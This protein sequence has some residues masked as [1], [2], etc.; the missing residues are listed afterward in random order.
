ML[1]YYNGAEVYLPK[2]NYVITDYIVNINGE[3]DPTENET[4]AMLGTAV[5][6]KMILGEEAEN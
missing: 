4:T 6:G 2:F 3:I 1:A 5:L